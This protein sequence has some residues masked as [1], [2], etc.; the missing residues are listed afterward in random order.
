MASG[1]VWLAFV[2]LAVFFSMLIPSNSSY[3]A[4]D[5]LIQGRGVPGPTPE[6]VL[7]A[8]GYCASSGGSTN[9]ESIN[10]VNLETL[11]D[12]KT[13]RLTVGV[14]IANPT[15]CVAGEPCPAYDSSP[16]YVNAWL[17]WNGNQQFEESEKVMDLEGSGYLNI[18][19]SGTM[20]FV[21][22]F[23]IPEEH[24]GNTWLRVNLGYGHDPNDPCEQSWTYGNVVDQEVELEVTKFPEVKD[25]KITPDANFGVPVTN[26]DLT[27]NAEITEVAGFEN[28]EIVW[29]HGIQGTSEELGMGDKRL[30]ER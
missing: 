16:E 2:F 13:M 12:K 19:Y 10:H 7:E 17:D 25:I 29:E 23:A 21:K 24:V 11:P 1:R 26:K 15:G 28:T 14:Y 5:G 27:F 20:T 9:Y 8:A 3:A 6:K 22:Q 30:C 18:N 4:S